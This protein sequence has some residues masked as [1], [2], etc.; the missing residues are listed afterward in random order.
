MYYE[1]RDGQIVA[2]P[3]ASDLDSPVSGIPE[4]PP[5]HDSV[6]GVIP[7]AETVS[8]I[9]APFPDDYVSSDEL[10]SALSD[11]M[12]KEDFQEYYELAEA[13]A[14]ASMYPIYPTS[15]FVSIFD[16]VLD[17]LPSGTPYVLVQGSDNYTADLYYSNVYSY[18][19]SSSVITLQAPVTHCRLYRTQTGGS[20]NY[21]YYYN[22]SHQSSDETFSLSSN[23]LLYTNTVE[24]YPDISPME[25]GVSWNTVPFFVAGI[26]A[27]LCLGFFKIGKRGMS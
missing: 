19:T 7:L 18:D 2:V 26:L 6:F 14:A 20:Y 27:V 21:N 5:D 25:S 13:R 16:Y 11:F 1:F 23:I 22:I 4:I 17:G 8:V 10:E 24:G 3:K 15:N 12:T 9:P